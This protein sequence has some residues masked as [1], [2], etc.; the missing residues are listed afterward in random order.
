MQSIGRLLNSL[1]SEWLGVIFDLSQALHN[2]FRASLT[3][4]IQVA[5][6]TAAGTHNNQPFITLFFTIF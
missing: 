4:P 5:S 2:R 6:S 3:I 1:I